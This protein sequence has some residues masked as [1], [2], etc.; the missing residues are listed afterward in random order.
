MA[1][2]RIG[3]ILVDLGFLTD[4]QLELVLDEQ[5]QHPGE[6][7][8][9]VAVNMLAARQLFRSISYGDK[10]GVDGH[11]AAAVQVMCGEAAVDASILGV[12]ILGG[13]GYMEDYGQEKRMRDAKQVQGIFGRKDLVLQD[14]AEALAV[15]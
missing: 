10:S 3:Q 12:Q 13:N 4:E 14:I 6:L 2:R 7:L 8:G 5:D 11:A 15:K 1:I 9:R